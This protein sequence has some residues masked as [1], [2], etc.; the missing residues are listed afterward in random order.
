MTN[1]EAIELTK[2]YMKRLIDC[3]EN[4]DDI[5]ELNKIICEALMYAQNLV[6]YGV[7]ISDKYSIVIIKM[8]VILVISMIR[9]YACI[10]H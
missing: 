3:G 5:G 9:Q 8:L 7:D 6:K 4:K 1:Q 10:M 2:E